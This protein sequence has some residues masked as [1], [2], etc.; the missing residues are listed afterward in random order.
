MIALGNSGWSQCNA[1]F[2]LGPDVTLCSGENVLLSAGTGFE[3]YLWDNGST[4]QSRLVSTAGTYSCTVTDFG[5]SGDLVTNGNFNAGA[6]GF[7]SDYALGT[8]GPWGLV[9]NAGTYGVGTNAQNLHSNFSPCTDH[10][11]GGSMLV[12]NGA[13]V[14]GQNVWC[15]TV[16]VQANTSYA[17]SAW[18][19]SVVGSSP[20]QLQFTVNG[21]AVGSGLNATTQTCNWLN[22]YGVWPSGSA[23][24]ATICISNVNT[25][26]SGNDFALDDISFAPFCTYTDEVVVSVQADPQPDL[27]PDI[28][29]C[30]GDGVTLDGTFP[31]ADSYTWQDGSTAASFSPAVS[32]TY[33]V[34][35]DINGCTGRDSV[36]VD[37]IPGPVVDLGPG[38]TRCAGERT[39]LNAFNAG[40]TYLWQDGSTGP[41][42]EVTTGGN[43]SVTATIGI[44]SA[45]DNVTFI[46]HPLPVVSL[47]ADTTLCADTALTFNVYRPG[48]SYLWQ[49]GT[50]MTELT[51][52][53]AGTYWVRVTENGCSTT[54]SMELGIIDL[55]E[56]DLGPD[57]LLCIGT[58]EVLDASGPDY[59]YAWTDGSDEARFTVTGPGL[60][61]VTVSNSCGAAS[62][63]VYAVQDY[64]DCP[65]Y[66][67]NAFSPN[68]DGINEGFVPWFDCPATDYVLRIYDRWGS[69]LWETDVPGKA[70]ESEESDPTGVY[71]WTLEMRP[72]AVG[73]NGMRRLSGHVVLLR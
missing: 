28:E 3:T 50:T 31:G 26:Q 47:G 40:A 43:Y 13:E 64:C 48:G 12:V 69:I 61:G 2:N 54:D 55:P 37:L 18:L 17:F 27:G 8:G 15:Q 21:V 51:T 30:M 33:W 66:A 9:S 4:A 68:G 39:M 42:F 16:N 7:T 19:A 71:M 59:S 6:T 70:W 72:M 32:G 49:D 23:T 56:V 29:A 10:T 67:P 60:Y 65:V 1:V 58:T 11:G 41:S 22:F 36:D 73:I 25:S 63:S 5:T 38:Q 44:C 53:A 24:V 34:E 14:A 52:S 20:A 35:V 45:T 46:Y 62:D 57:F